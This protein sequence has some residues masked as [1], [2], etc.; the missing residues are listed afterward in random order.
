[1]IVYDLVCAAAHRFEA[2]FGNSGDYDGQKAR[3]LLSCPI[4]GSAEVGK[5]VMAPAVPAKGNQRTAPMPDPAARL[6]EMQR[7]LEAESQYVGPRFAEEARAIH[8]SGE[9][10]S[11][12]GEASAEEVKALREEGV[13]LLPL[14]FRPLAGSDA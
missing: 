9:A 3:G 7:A 6:L 10:R 14:P 13:P 8:A 1:M 4:C 11:V 2:W 12:H 5:A